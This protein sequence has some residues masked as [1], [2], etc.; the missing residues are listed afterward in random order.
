MVGKHP[1]INQEQ[2]PKNS[3]RN[4]YVYLT[5]YSIMAVLFLFNLK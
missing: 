3:Q 5:A 4:P 2:Q 1:G